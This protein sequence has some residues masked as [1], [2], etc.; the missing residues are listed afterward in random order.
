ML[1]KFKN[2]IA[3][4]FWL[5]FVVI[6]GT[7]LILLFV[8]VAYWSLDANHQL[9]WNKGLVFYLFFALVPL[10]YLYF[11][12]FKSS[13]SL[14]KSLF[15]GGSTLK[16][17]TKFFFLRL[18]FGFLIVSL[19]QPIYGTKTASTIAKNAEIVLA[20]DV[21]NSM[22]AA[23]IQEGTSRLEIAK[24]ASVEL[25]NGLHGERVGLLIFAGNAYV[26]LPITKDYSS[27][28]LFSKELESKM[29]SLQ[30]TNFDAAIQTSLQM[31]K[32]D[33]SSKALIVMTDGENH[34]DFPEQALSELKKKGVK[35]LTVGIGTEKGGLIPADPNHPEYGFKRDREGKVVLSRVNTSLIKKMANESKGA[36][37][38]VRTPFP[39][40]SDIL[41]QIN[42][43]KG[44]KVRDLD[45]EI[46]ENHYRLPL[47]L[48]ILFWMLSLIEPWSLWR[49]KK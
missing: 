48:G 32:D 2:Q 27:I 24:R 23:D 13:S 6:E 30:G 8:L 40:L 11:N 45:L 49:S 44:E 3:K 39:D 41:T 43:L 36:A 9:S 38:F 34:L 1:S 33:F 22:N 42:Q 19:A 20:I 31:F 17:F 47:L 37:Y 28:K 14:S 21:S 5:Q 18:T 10:Y 26:Q 46:A 15:G 4:S 12:Y 25:M 29:V 35:L 16:S 7:F